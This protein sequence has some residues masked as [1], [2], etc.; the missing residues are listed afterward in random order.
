MGVGL[1]YGAS[2]KVLHS[3]PDPRVPPQR[4]IFYQDTQHTYFLTY[5]EEYHMSQEIPVL[6]LMG[7]PYE[8]GLTH[9]REQK[10]KIAEFSSSVLGVHQ[11]G[12]ASGTPGTIDNIEEVLKKG[13]LYTY[14]HIPKL[15]NTA[16]Q[17]F[18]KT[19]RG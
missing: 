17:Q 8:R 3:L 4:V 18:F 13:I 1:L 7:S 10:N 6:K 5:Q 19:A 2:L 16:S 14:N 11:A 9:A 12:K 15:L